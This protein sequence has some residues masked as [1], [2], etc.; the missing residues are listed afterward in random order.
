M[1]IRYNLSSFTA[2]WRVEP[3]IGML[4]NIALYG[5]DVV[6]LFG[7]FYTDFISWLIYMVSNKTFTRVMRSY[8]PV[9]H[10]Q[11]HIRARRSFVVLWCEFAQESEKNLALSLWPKDTHQSPIF[12][13]GFI[14]YT[15]TA[16]YCNWNYLKASYLLHYFTRN[17]C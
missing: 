15:I 12:F 1:L 9:G 14:Y 8:V 11:S 5:T 2:F 4:A 13:M 3:D 7:S 17:F 16:S 10:F 6:G